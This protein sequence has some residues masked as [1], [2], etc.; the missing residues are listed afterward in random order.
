VSKLD[1]E[2][3]V[4]RMNQLAPRFLLF[5]KTGRRS[6]SREEPAKSS[7]AIETAVFIF[8]CFVIAAIV[9]IAFQKVSHN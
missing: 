7:P 6:H 2:E 4:F 8:F 3:S 9:V 1:R 5:L